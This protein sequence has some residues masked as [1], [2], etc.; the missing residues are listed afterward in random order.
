M[1]KNEVINTYKE[2]S[3]FLASKML[4]DAFDGLFKLI[5]ETKTGDHQSRLEQLQTTYKF[6]L[7][8]TVEG[9]NDPERHKIYVNLLT[10]T[11]TLLEE[12]KQKL[13]KENSDY[14]MLKIQADQV[15][16]FIES[17]EN[18]M[19]NLEKYY[20]IVQ[21][22]ELDEESAKSNETQ[23]PNKALW[24]NAEKLF[25]LLWTTQFY[26]D[27][28]VK[29]F[30]GI[31]KS[32]DIPVFEKCV[33]VS[34]I[35]FSL[36]QCFDE[37][38]ILLLFDAIE[39]TNEEIAQRALIGLL[40]GLYIYDNRISLYPAIQNRLKLLAENKRR[41]KSIENI[42]KQLIQSKETEEIT[43]KL[44]EDILPEVAKISPHI[45]EKLDLDKLLGENMQD[46]QNPDWQDMFD[47]VPG[48][49]KKMEEFSNLQ[50]EGADV[51]MSTF[52]QLKTFPF[53]NKFVNWLYPFSV[54]HPDAEFVT[55]NKSNEAFIK[56][57]SSTSFLCNS[58]KYSFIFSISQIPESYKDMMA[59]AIE[60]EMGQMGEEQK[61]QSLVDPDK[62]SAYIS[63]QYIQDL[64]RLFKL[65]PSKH[66]LS[67]VFTWKL[68]FF[69]KKFTHILI[70]D[71]EVW[72]NI[73]SYYFI[74]GHYESAANIFE[75]LLLKNPEA[76]LYQKTGFCYQKNGDYKQALNFYLKADL[77]Q[78]KSLWTLRKIAQCYRS[79]KKPAEA[80]E[81]YMQAEQIKPDNQA[82]QLSIGNC[83]YELQEYDEALKRYFKLEYL[84]PSNIRIWRPIAWVSF[85]LEKYDQAE[86]FYTKILDAEPNRHDLI[87]AGHLQ[88]VLG[89]RKQALHFYQRSVELEDNTIEDFLE[90]FKEDKPL[91]LEKNIDPEDIPIMLD[92]LRYDL[93]D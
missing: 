60:A 76:E 50:M 93:N 62:A 69:N 55:N 86:K 21:L 26:T 79:L 81:Y 22:A 75:R 70:E 34:A 51:F 39:N 4:K 33:S 3:A 90:V 77:L 30:Q 15:T 89:N 2:I 74:K 78:S 42:F 23:S 54:H 36:M 9:I 61:D 64:Y 37:Q 10:S 71:D 11:Y 66:E 53:F 88:W 7:K 84:D 63:N 80:L 12:L 1:T 43:R 17:P 25:Q 85:L 45:R 8:Y 19:A 41:I 38:K 91:M 73:G 47:E 83:Y 65:H 56:A 58:D 87:N 40:I 92:R 31:L 72:R 48:L 49:T 13:L 44:K 46:D 32:E 82:M 68:N 20:S 27:R 28:E 6:M 35:T 29:L 14:S 67:D 52:S 59:S 5:R 57:L 16:N 18:M 24:E